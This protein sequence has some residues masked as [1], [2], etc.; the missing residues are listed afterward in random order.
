MDARVLPGMKY[1][2]EQGDH[3]GLLKAGGAYAEL[4]N[5]QYA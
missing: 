2:I 1:I 5:S 3:R 4:Y